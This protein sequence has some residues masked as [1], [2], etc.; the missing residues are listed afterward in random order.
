M[1]HMHNACY[2]CLLSVA[3]QSPVKSCACGLY[4]KM[5][6]EMDEDIGIAD[7]ISEVEK[8]DRISEAYSPDA[9]AL[10]LVRWSMM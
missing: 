3:S 5:L 2:V 10:R 6:A 4:T 8:E 1:Q 7:L 9:R